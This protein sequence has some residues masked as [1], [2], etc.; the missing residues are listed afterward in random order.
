M[1]FSKILKSSFHFIRSSNHKELLLFTSL[2]NGK[3]QRNPRHLFFNFHWLSLACLHFRPFH[4]KWMMKQRRSHTYKH[5]NT[6]NV[7]HRRHK[8]ML[9]QQT[10]SVTL[11]QEE[12]IEWM[13]IQATFTIIRPKHY[14]P[15]Y[16]TQNVFH[17][18]SKKLQC[19]KN[20]SDTFFSWIHLKKYLSPDCESHNWISLVKWQCK[21][22]IL[23]MPHPNL[24][25]IRF[26]MQKV[27][28]F[29]SS[30][31]QKEAYVSYIYFFSK[32]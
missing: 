30:L 15:W 21:Q 19:R 3:L 27:W 11:D 18:S 4:L 1:K 5:M 31:S 9:N 14:H 10:E 32:K 7:V 2:R 22:I 25:A 24:L 28:E 17:K 29:C 26:D 13:K 6:K 8:P 12:K 16:L 23:I 20:V